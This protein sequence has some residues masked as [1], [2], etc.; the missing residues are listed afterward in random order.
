MGISQ[1]SVWLDK[2]QLVNIIS[3]P[4]LIRANYTWETVNT[5]DIGIDLNLLRNRM[6]MTFDWYSRETTGMLGNGVELPS[7]V[8]A[9]AP[10]QN[11]S[12]MKTRGWELSLNW[13]DNIGDVSYRVGFNLYDHKSKITKFNNASGNLGS[14]YVGQVLGEIWGY[15][16]DGYYSI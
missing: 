11:V 13:H 6:S 8:G 15:K 7:V 9:A 10:L 2:Q 14:R 4:G 16:A 12:D 1:S 5:F 3:T